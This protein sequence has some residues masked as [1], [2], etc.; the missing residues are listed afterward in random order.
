LAHHAQSEIELA[1]PTWVTLHYLNKYRNSAE[2]L[3]YFEQQPARIYE[4]RI[5]VDANE[6]HVAMWYGDAGYAGYAGYE[7]WDAKQAG[8][9]HRLILTKGAYRFENSFENSVLNE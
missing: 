7:S 1:P 6:A 9:R 4:T 2:A 3:R 5:A 8:V